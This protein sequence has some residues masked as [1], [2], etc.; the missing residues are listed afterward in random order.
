MI[1]IFRKYH[2]LGLQLLNEYFNENQVLTRNLLC[3]DRGASSKSLTSL[4]IAAEIKNKEFVAHNSSQDLLDTK[5]NGL[6]EL[7]DDSKIKV[8]FIKN[9]SELFI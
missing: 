4:K 1:F 6:L 2:D 8:M 5:W 7:Q 3:D 9:L